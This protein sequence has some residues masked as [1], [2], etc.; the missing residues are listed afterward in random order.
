MYRRIDMAANL[1]ENDILICK[2]KRTDLRT[3][4]QKVK[5]S[6]QQTGFIFVI[7]VKDVLIHK[8]QV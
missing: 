5:N 4:R 6:R 7:H 2:G 8:I 1:S 3:G